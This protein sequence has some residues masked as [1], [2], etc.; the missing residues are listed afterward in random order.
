MYWT[1]IRPFYT[2]GPPLYDCKYIRVNTY[3]HI[4]PGYWGGGGAVALLGEPVVPL[5]PPVPTPLLD[6]GVYMYVGTHTGM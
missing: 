2:L 4:W 3:I 6:C 1:G 5:A